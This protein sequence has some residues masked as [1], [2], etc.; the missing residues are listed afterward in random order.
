MDHDGNNRLRKC[1][2]NRAGAMKLDEIRDDTY[3]K[4]FDV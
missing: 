3:R 4:L 1:A 2:Y